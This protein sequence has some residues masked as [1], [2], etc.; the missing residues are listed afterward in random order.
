MNLKFLNKLKKIKYFDL[1]LLI[2]ISIFLFSFISLS[3]IYFFDDFGYLVILIISLIISFIPFLF[4]SHFLNKIKNIYDNLYLLLNKDYDSYISNTKLNNNIKNQAEEL[5]LSIFSLVKTIIDSKDKEESIPENFDSLTKINNRKTLELNINKHISIAN[6][7]NKKCLFLTIDIDN[8]SDIN[9]NYGYFIGDEILKN[10]TSIINHHLNI[11][12]YSK[13]KYTFGKL[14]GDEFGIFIYDTDDSLSKDFITELYHDL[15]NLDHYLNNHKITTTCS[16]GIS[17]YPDNG[18]FLNDLLNN[19][20]LSMK[21][22]KKS[23]HKITH[24]T[25][26]DVDLH[27]IKNKL[28]WNEKAKNELS[29]S[30]LKVY[31]QP[32]MNIKENIISHYECLLRININ[33]EWVSPY[34]YV[35]ASE[36]TGQ[37]EKLDSF[38]IDK[39]F[40]YISKLNRKE[41]L[42]DLKFSINISGF[43]IS[44]SNIFYYIS[45]KQKEY[46]IN[47]NSVIFEITET[48]IIDN[49]EEAIININ[50]IKNL[51]YLFALDDFGIGF[52]NFKTIKGIPA[53][54][55]KIDGSFVKNIH[56][57]SDNEII[58]KA[59]NYMSHQFH[60][61][62]IAEFVE[63][64]EILENLK[65][66]NVDYAQGYHI[67]KPKSFYDTFNL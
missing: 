48:S 19:A 59:I 54:F 28:Y 27:H 49:F 6:R 32:I 60:R 11:S 4:L 56:E 24:F 17:I 53:D 1:R 3:S 52:S 8:F 10:V 65:N 55:I 21:H 22:S 25:E 66:L 30:F 63:N 35:L 13:D 15:L 61:K 12:Y 39:V 2:S 44:S 7:N 20:S 36:R 37:I 58:V 64:E 45:K 50:K 47:P 34:Q 18:N 5:N 9:H 40:Y 51:G 67:G 23:S 26:N 57:S 46:N 31:F 16:I 38:I 41:K 42:N 14:N 62:T 33:N 29:D 43:T